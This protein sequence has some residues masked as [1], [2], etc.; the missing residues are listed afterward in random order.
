MLNRRRLLPDVGES[1]VDEFLDYLFTVANLVPYAP[2]LRPS[3]RDPADELI[4][5][6]AVQ[7]GA[8]IVTHNKKISPGPSGLAF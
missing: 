1:D 2:R 5:E 8:M 3:L 6:A 4:L 7:C